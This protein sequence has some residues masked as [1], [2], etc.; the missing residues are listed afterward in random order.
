MLGAAVPSTALPP[1]SPSAS[2]RLWV[3]S[4]AGVIVHGGCGIG[5]VSHRHVSYSDQLWWTFAL[6]G[7][8]PRMLRASLGGDRAGQRLRAAETCCGR[9]VRSPRSP[10]PGS[11]ARGGAPLIALSDITLANAALTGDKRLLF[12]DGRRRLRDVPDRRPQLDCARRS[13]G[14][15]ARRRRSWC[16]DCVRSPITHGG[17][18]VFYQVGPEGLALYVDLGLAAAED[19]RGRRACRSRSSR[20]RAPARARRLRAIAPPRAGATVA[21]FEVL[22]PEAIEPLLP[23]LQRISSAW[24]TRQIHRR[25]SAF[26]RGGRFSPQYLRQFPLAVVRCGGAPAAFREPVDHGNPGRAVGGSDALRSGGA[27][28]RHGLPVRRADAV[29]GGEAGFRSFNLGM[30]PLS[31]LETHPPRTRVAPGRQ[32]HLP[33]RRAL[34]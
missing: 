8:A 25:R 7:N 1:F 11:W 30:A 33:P 10:D 34:L 13:G 26:F 23:V 27:A 3:V 31:G 21:T 20:S 15:T 12:S 18:T 16:G 5:I 14:L 28:Q 2:R 4:I 19:R 9:R 6:Y 32:L 29:G 24:L 22:P 17:E